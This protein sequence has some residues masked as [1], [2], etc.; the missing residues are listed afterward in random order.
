MSPRLRLILALTPVAIVPC[1]GCIRPCVCEVRVV[2]GEG[3]PCE[4][5][6]VE[7]SPD[8]STTDTDAVINALGV[9]GNAALDAVLGLIF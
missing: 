9:V 4:V 1:A 5:T 3:Q 7:A 8:P 6:V 2:P